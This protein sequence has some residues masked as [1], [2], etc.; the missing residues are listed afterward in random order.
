MI[1]VRSREIEAGAV[2]PFRRVRISHQAFASIVR[3]TDRYEVLGEPRSLHRTAV[4]TGWTTSSAKVLWVLDQPGTRRHGRRDRRGRSRGARVVGVGQRDHG[5]RARLPSRS[6]ARITSSRCA[7]RRARR[8]AIATAR[9]LFLLGG[10][11]PAGSVLDFDA[12]AISLLRG[13]ESNAFAGSRVALVNAD[14]RWPFARPERGYRTWPLFLHTAHAAVFADVGPCVVGP[15][16]RL[17]DVKTSLGGELSADVVV[18]YSL[19]L[20]LA[21]GGA[22]GHDAQ[23]RTDHATVYVRVGHAF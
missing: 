19:R 3:T 4:R 9:R 15:V 5:R 23:R 20:T 11:A 7:R 18:G 22:W 14:Y 10:A 6:G 13:F 2:V 17:A 16:R 21:A 1:P 8:T 12:D